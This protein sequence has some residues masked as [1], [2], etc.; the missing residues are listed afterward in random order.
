MKRL[1]FAAVLAGIMLLSGCEATELGGRAIIQAAA[2]DFDGHEYIVSALLFSSGGGSGG[3]IDPSNENVIKVT[4]RGATFAAAVD[5]ISLTDGKEIYM[6]ENRLLILGSGFSETDV[7]PVLETAARDMRCSLNM[8]VCCADDPEF[9]TDMHFTEGITA[10]QK[11]VDMI[12]NAYR[13]GGSPQADLLTLLN[14]TAA[15]RKSMIPMFSP[16]QNGFG[17]TSDEDGMTAVL[18]GSR[19]LSGG[20]LTDRLD[21]RAT[22]G[23]ML[24]SGESDHAMLTFSHGGREYSCE[25]NCVK[26]ERQASGEIR[27]SARLRRRN[28]EELPEELRQAAMLE[29][30][31]L[32]NVAL[33]AE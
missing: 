26:V 7:T 16:E 20:K 3:E 27:I 13:A 33:A 2:V 8:L 18:S 12:E 1:I 14:N 5:D 15:G 9:L 24:V 22:A 4:G 10:A 28:G 21:S 32:V 19:I 23:E 6:S 30:D 11:P 25:A 17:M 31:T 29:L